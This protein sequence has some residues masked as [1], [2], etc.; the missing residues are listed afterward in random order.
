MHFTLSVDAERARERRLTAPRP[1]ARDLALVGATTGVA[2][3][4]A[5]PLSWSLALLAGALAG[6]LGAL[7]GALMPRLLHRRVRRRSWLLLAAAAVGLGGLWGGAAGLGAGVLAGASWK[8]SA[9]VFAT[10]GAV[11]LGWVWLPLV[12]ARARGRST[13]PLVAL[14]SVAAPAAGYLAYLHLT[15]T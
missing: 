8:W 15:W 14:A 12:M 1:W 5:T 3:A 7:L 13:W 2:L 11:Q 6:T 4:V 10:A 9:A